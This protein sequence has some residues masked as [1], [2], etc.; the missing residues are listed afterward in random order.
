MGGKSGGGTTTTKTEPWDEQKPYLQAGFQALSSLANP[1]FKQTKSTAPVYSNK[2]T[3]NSATETYEPTLVK[4]GKKSTVTGMNVVDNALAP[5][6][7]QDNTVAP[8]SSYTKQAITMQANAAKNMS[9]DANMKAATAAAQAVSNGTAL[10]N[11]AGLSALNRYAAQDFNAGNA[12]LQNL[13]GYTGQGINSGNSALAV[14][15]ELSQ[16]DNPYMDSLYKRANNQAQA[17]LDSN[18]NRSGRYGSGSHEAAA[19]DAANNLADQMYSSLYDKR[20]NAANAA[21]G[22]Y[23]Q[24]MG[25]GINAQQAAGQL[26]NQGLGMNINAAQDAAGAYNTGVGQRLQAAQLGQQLANQKYTDAAMLSEAGGLKD[27]YNQQL[28]NAAIERYNYEAQRPLQMLSN[29][30]SMISGNFGGTTTATGQQASRSR[31]GGALGGA[32]SG[33]SIGATVGGVP[34]AVIGGLGGSLLGLF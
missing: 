4:S 12:A 21:S 10:K 24:G 8:Q 30:N 18:F 31:L 27:D 6:Y 13:Y 34:G 16:N 17:S 33:A 3:W 2:L 9:K 29:Y 19:A 7:Y 1:W 26:Y 23:L 11:N 15:N 22:S 25:Q 20:I 14:L 28:I 5:A 32:L